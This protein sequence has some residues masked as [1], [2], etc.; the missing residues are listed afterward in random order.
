MSFADD[1]KRFNVKV[2]QLVDQAFVNVA[3]AAHESIVNGSP[4]T[5]APGQPVDTGNLR[6]SWHLEFPSK[7]SAVISTNVEY[8]PYVEAGVAGKGGRP[9]HY[10]NHGPHSVAHTIA[11]IQPLVD[12]EVR[13]LKGAG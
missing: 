13:K 10:Q 4:V 8:A 12:H 2:E 5:G 6:A 1:I 9:A 3:S 7:E 11:R